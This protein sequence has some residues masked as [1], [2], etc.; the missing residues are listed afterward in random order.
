MQI[1]SG[2]QAL[3]DCALYI[4]MPPSAQAIIRTLKIFLTFGI[5]NEGFSGLPSPDG[6]FSKLFD[7]NPQSKP[8]LYC[9]QRVHWWA[10][11]RQNRD[12]IV[13]DFRVSRTTVKDPACSG[14][15]SCARRRSQ[16]QR[17]RVTVPIHNFSAAFESVGS[18]ASCVAGDDTT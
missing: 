8:Y 3:R 9:R 17:H 5:C 16:A 11:L 14:L 13:S 7:G 15:I 6:L 12:V 2:F 10:G 18:P 4:E 1:R